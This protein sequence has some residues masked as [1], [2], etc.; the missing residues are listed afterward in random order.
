[1][2]GK[3]FVFGGLAHLLGHHQ[4]F[5]AN[6]FVVAKVISLVKFMPS[7]KLRAHCIPQQFHEFDALDR[8]VTVRAAHELIEIL[9][10][11]GNFE[12]LGVRREIDQ[13]ASHHVFYDLPNSRIGQIGSN[14]IRHAVVEVGQHVARRPRSGR[15]RHRVGKAPK[16]ITPRQHFANLRLYAAEI[17][18]AG[19]FDPFEQQSG[20]E[21]ELNRQPGATLEHESR[22][23]ASARKKLIYLVNV[24]IAKD[25]FPGN[26]NLVEND[27]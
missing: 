4:D 1:M 24:S 21:I 20:D 12:I 11:F 22:Q 6:V 7:G 5:N 15:P 10:N 27:D 9:A 25:V 3:A 2:L 8:G 18:R 19:S 17:L 26:K 23:E 13:R 16:Q 14:A